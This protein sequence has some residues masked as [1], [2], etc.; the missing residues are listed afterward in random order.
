[1]FVTYG[2]NELTLKWHRPCPHERQK[3]R[4]FFRKGTCFHENTHK[5]KSCF[6]NCMFFKSCFFQSYVF[7]KN[8]AI[9][10]SHF[11]EAL[12]LYNNKNGK[13]MRLWRKIFGR[14]YSWRLSCERRH[15][16]MRKNISVRFLDGVILQLFN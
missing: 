4:D 16:I 15:F 9:F 12:A 5:R 3:P 1:M 10:F 11:D 8:R 13:I 7:L 14:I 6:F 2:K